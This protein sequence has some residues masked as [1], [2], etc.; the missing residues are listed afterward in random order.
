MV[1]SR[2]KFRLPE[3]VHSRRETFCV[4]NTSLLKPRQSITYLK[5]RGLKPLLVIC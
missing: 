3:S 4:Q 1:L 5:D 2:G